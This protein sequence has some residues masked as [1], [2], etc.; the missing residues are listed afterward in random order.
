MARRLPPLNAL[1]AFE[2]AG[3]HLSFTL[4]AKELNV[5]P[6]AIS[7]Q[8]KLLEDTFGFQLFE[9]KGGALEATPRCKVYAQSL[10]DVFSRIETA[11]NILRD[12]ERE[13]ELCV[14]ASVTF[15]L[16]WLVPRMTHLHARHPEWTL[17]LTAAVPPPRLNDGGEADVFIQLNDG[18]QTDLKCERLLGNDLVPV[19][20]PAL[21]ASGPP[22]ETPSDLAH[23]RLLHSL[24]RPRHWP[25]WLA[26]TGTTDVDG[27]GG[28][29][30][31]T[32]ALCYQAAIEG[33][34][35]AMAQVNFVIDDIVAGRLVTP[36]R[37]IVEDDEAFFFTWGG[38]PRSTKLDQFRSWIFQEAA[39]H[40]ARIRDLTADYR[41]VAK[42]G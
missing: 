7:R 18:T 16:L 39:A 4:A 29:F 33:L 36:F 10:S 11:T 23:H 34:G 40:E 1:R 15:T 9:R 41:R 26:A 6:G 38:R 37:T 35:V 5:T 22:L 31:G 17:R 12:S 19:C 14:S 30:L 32:S 25:D 24:L 13:R 27:S 28:T 20:S 3:R 2:S 8:I 42:S 21:L